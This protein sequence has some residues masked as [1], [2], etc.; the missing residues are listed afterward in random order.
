MTVSELKKRLIWKINHTDNNEI[1]EEMY[2]LI[3]NEEI[4][5]KIYILSAEQKKAV[6]ESQEQFRNGQYLSEEK[7]DKEIDQ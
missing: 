3:S 1:L 4:T 5:E 2:R 6:Q 7:A